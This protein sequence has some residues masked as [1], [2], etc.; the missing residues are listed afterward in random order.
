MYLDGAAGSIE[1]VPSRSGVITPGTW[2]LMCQKD[3][4]LVQLQVLPRRSWKDEGQV[5]GSSKRRREGPG[6]SS[7]RSMDG[8]SSAVSQPSE[9]VL[10]STHYPLLTLMQGQ[11]ACLVGQGNKETYT[12]TH[13]NRLVDTKAARLYSATHSNIPSPVV[14]KVIKAPAGC[15]GEKEC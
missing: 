13:L 5:A 10:A 7:K 1:L 14:V 11:T 12:I 6:E 2:R 3:V 4:P 8:S 15:R 9:T